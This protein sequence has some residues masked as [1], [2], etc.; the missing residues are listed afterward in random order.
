MTRMFL[1]RM[2]ALEYGRDDS[3]GRSARCGRAGYGNEVLPAAFGETVP[4]RCFSDGA[5][6]SNSAA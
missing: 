2:S 3:T 1:C 5:R 6:S 4:S